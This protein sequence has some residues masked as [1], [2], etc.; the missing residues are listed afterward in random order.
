[1]YFSGSGE[2]FIPL[3]PVFLAIKLWVM[4]MDNDTIA[5]IATALS[6]SGI[7]IIRMSGAES[8]SITDKIFKTKSGKCLNISSKPTHTIHYGYIYDGDE[9]VDEVLVMKMD[10]PRSY[11]AE[12]TIEINCHGGPYLMKRV[13]DIVIKYGARAADPGEFTKRAFM[14]GRIDLTEAESVMELIS[15]KNEFARRNSLRTLRGSVYKIIEELREKILH[16]TAFIEAALDDPEHYDLDGYPPQLR[17]I[18]IGLIDNVSEL[19]ENSGSGKLLADGIQTVIVGKPNAGKSSL[20][21]MLLGEEKAIVTDVAG[22]TRDAVEANLKLGEIVLNIVDTAGIRDTDDTVESIGVDKSKKLADE[23]EL[24]LYVIDSSV[25]LDENDKEIID[26]ISGHNVI[27]ILNKSDLETVVSEED[28]NDMLECPIVSASAKDE[29]G[30]EEL[31]NSV[32]KMFF[33]GVLE[34]ND[35]VYIT[36]KRQIESLKNVKESL[37]LVIN[38]IDS[39]MS[40]DLFSIDLMDAYNCL[41]SIIGEDTDDDLADKIFSDFCMGK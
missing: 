15:S 5:A 18:V 26:I 38:S 19:L 23:A 11:T 25:P 28:I 27:V 37:K 17:K 40:E 16:E 6:P 12:D 24:I 21:N 13:L 14:N 1:M 4:T 3:L 32:E 39:Q 2:Y 33:D 22:T 41:G 31:K 35:E 36:N 34:H 9:A 8:F 29:K 20:L 30:I 10:G 7:G